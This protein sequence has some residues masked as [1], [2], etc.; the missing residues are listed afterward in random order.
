MKVSRMMMARRSLWQ[1]GEVVDEVVEI[2]KKLMAVS[3]K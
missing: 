3:R 2:W 1:R